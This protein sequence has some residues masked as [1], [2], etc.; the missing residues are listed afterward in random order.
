VI[1]WYTVHCVYAVY[2]SIN[3]VPLCRAERPKPLA[4]TPSSSSLTTSAGAWKSP[5]HT[6]AWWLTWLGCGCDVGVKLDVLW[7]ETKMIDYESQDSILPFFMHSISFNLFDW[8]FNVWI[9]LVSDSWNPAAASLESH[10]YGPTVRKGTGLAL[11]EMTWH[12]LASL[13]SSCYG[14]ISLKSMLNHM[15]KSNKLP[16]FPFSGAAMCCFPLLLLSRSRA[17]SP[18]SR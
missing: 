8:T 17:T 16:T 9:C 12:K 5:R 1:S 3:L 6:P 7:R 14:G 4:T 11:A 10:T 2:A 18:R 15:C 13:K